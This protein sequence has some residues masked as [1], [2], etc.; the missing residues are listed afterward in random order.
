L[1]V[2]ELIRRYALAARAICGGRGVRVR[3][4][5]PGNDERLAWSAGHIG[6]GEEPRWTFLLDGRGGPLGCLE[7]FH[8]DGEAAEHRAR[9]CAALAEALA[10]ELDRLGVG[11]R[12]ESFEVEVGHP[13]LARAVRFILCRYR[14]PL[15]LARV[16]SH[17][18]VSESHLCHLFQ[19]ELGTTFVSFVNR[20]RVDHARRLLLARTDLTVTRV[21]LRAGFSD[22]RQFQRVFKALAGCTASELRRLGARARR[23][24]VRQGQQKSPPDS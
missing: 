4:E 13:A 5:N 11:R 20:L 23:S 2:T 19:Q 12:E 17:A 14:T 7:L 8:G 22:L 1:D 9:D 21:A 15:R 6:A 18:H 3:V 10:R 16:A 24:P